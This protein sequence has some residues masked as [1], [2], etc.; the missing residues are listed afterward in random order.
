MPPQPKPTCT[1]ACLGKSLRGRTHSKTELG[2]SPY[3]MRTSGH[4]IWRVWVCDVWVA[5]YQPTLC[6][7][8]T[9]GWARLRNC[10]Q[11]VRRLLAQDTELRLNYLKLNHFIFFAMRL[12]LCLT[13]ARCPQGIPRGGTRAR[14]FICVANRKELCGWHPDVLFYRRSSSH[15]GIC[16]LGCLRNT[17]ARTRQGLV[18]EVTWTRVPRIVPEIR[19]NQYSCTGPWGWSGHT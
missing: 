16:I 14:T 17:N 9:S 15:V 5:T 19:T 2:K 7:R 13:D 4:D 3:T 11:A 18:V 12:Y 10:Q 1:W 6:K 8:L